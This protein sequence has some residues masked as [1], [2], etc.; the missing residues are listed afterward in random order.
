MDKSYQPNSI[1]THWAK[2]WEKEG[3]MQPEGD[4][5]SY[6]IMLPPPNVTGSLHMGHGFQQTLMDA[7]IRR[8]RMQNHCT[9]W[10][11][12]TD[13]AG[14]ATQ[15]L[16]ERKLANKGQNRH[17]LGREKFLKKMWEWVDQSG[18]TITRQIRRLGASIDWSRERFS[19]DRGISHATREA[20]IKLYEEGLIYR[21]KRLVNWDPA[22]HTAISDLEVVNEIKRGN[23]WYIH[24]PLTSNDG[25]ITVATTR[26]E[27]MLGDAAVA[28]HPDDERFNTLIG[29]TLKLPLTDREIPIIADQE[30]DPEF[31]TGCVKITPAHDFNDN[32][33]GMRHDLPLITILN[34]D[35]TINDNAP[36]KY[37]GLDRFE[38]RKIII[39][40]LDDA[41]LL[42]KTE[43]HQLSVPHGDRSGVV[44][45]PL[46]TDQWFVKTE[47]LAKPAIEAVKNGDIEFV[48][49][50]W[51][52]TYLQWLENIQDWCIS[53]QLWWGHRIP[54][55]YDIK[56]NIYVGH[57]EADV[58]KRYQLSDEL[59]LRQDDDV[60]DTWFS[61]SLWPFA[62][63]GWPEETDALN[64]F[65]PTSVLVT[66]FDII[67]FWV[68]RMVMMGIKLRGNVPFKKV[69]I[70]GLIRDQYG[71]KMSK[72]KGNV[73]D[74]IDLIDGI[75]LES[76]VKKRCTG[77]M[78][79]QME[80]AIEKNTRK[81]F[82]DGINAHGT[83][84][85]RFTFC[86]L[87]S[88]GR[89]IN[90]DMGRI[91]GYRNFCNKIWNA[92]R[93]VL[94]HTEKKTLTGT[95][96]NYSLADQWIQSQLQKTIQRV[97]DAFNQFRFDL[98]ANALYEFT[99]NEYC[100]WYLEFAKC[101]LLDENTSDAQRLGTRQTLLNV[102][103][104]VLRL[105]HPLMPFITEEI[106]QRVAPLLE[107]TG[108]TI[109][110]Q[111]YPAFDIS[112]LN[113]QAFDEIEGLKEIITA[114]RTMRGEMNVSPAKS[115]D[116]VLAKGNKKDR[117]LID[118]CEYYLH[119]LARVNTIR[120]LTEG[121]AP[122]VA[123]TSIVNTLEIYIPL[124]GLIDKE[125]ELKR[126]EK[127][128]EKLNKEILKSSHKLDNPS[129]V[130]KAPAAVVEQERERLKG[131]EHTLKK[132]QANFERI[133]S[134]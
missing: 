43:P 70:T 61:S 10:Q 87:A 51:A 107:R 71:K 116:I 105:M 110:L 84:A 130:E 24:Y 25:F 124:T 34:L 108:D 131:T 96:I 50:N 92:A 82:P 27:T 21:G 85:L 59:P 122:P 39:K 29:K 109:M 103:E 106:W 32:A 89:D 19:M 8:E 94:M 120:W 6:C 72:S 64:R 126:L 30:V 113:E 101:L 74:P 60:L 123:A 41:G 58:R 1:E 88:T 83:D 38:A 11:A 77:L 100:D 132:L 125:A 5:P 112:Q 28:V 9:L 62:T 95:D 54:V 14:I 117:Q 36:K 23:M 20:F 119:R 129:Y 49:A 45:E 2:Q 16:V 91:E 52:K 67:F 47:T 90:F 93:F 99:W 75:D 18:K 118:D 40:D 115:I 53:R 44:I 26:P 73:L 76:L 134:L 133:R 114:I 63:L 12:G 121:K 86:A 33:M 97:N 104:T 102:L 4:G 68:A 55:W 13:H 42:E 22:L 66:G 79:P 37:R 80:N 69:Y 56:D 46:L 57:D 127:E 17:D 65:Y 78:Q 98:V 3:Y 81:E 7:L 35:A 48:P 15:M 128:M 31:G 111:P